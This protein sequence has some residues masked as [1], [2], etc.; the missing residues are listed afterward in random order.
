MPSVRHLSWRRLLPSMD[1]FRNAA[2]GPT[3]QV[4]N[5]LLAINVSTYLVAKFDH[6]VV[7]SMAA[8]PYEIAKGEW[9]RLLTCGFLHTD[10]LHILVR[11]I[12]GFE[13]A[14]SGR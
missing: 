9:Y 11:S 14:T 7:V 12:L 3:R 4:T 2:E 13:R 8:I 10:F 1:D 5:L 6:G